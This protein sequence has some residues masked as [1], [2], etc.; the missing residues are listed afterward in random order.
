MVL[1]AP[2]PVGAV[3]P[4][5]ASGRS[6]SADLLAALR[7]R[8]QAQ[9]RFDPCLA[10][11]LRAWLE[12]AAFGVAAA[13]GE[14]TSPLFVGPRRV[15]GP[16]EGAPREALSTERVLSRLV[17]ALFR[18]LVTVG[19]VGDP[20]TDA[21]DALRADGG[22]DGVVGTVE[23]LANGPRAVLAEALGRHAAHLRDLVPRFA[24]SWMPR[25]D[26]R[27]AIPLAG[28]RVVLG[29]A[30]DLLIRPGRPHEASLCA[31]G[32]ATE[33]PW[34]AERRSLHYLVLLETLRSGTPPFRVALVE[35]ATGRW[36]LEDVREEHV[37]AVAAHVAA[38]LSEQ[39]DG[40][41]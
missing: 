20:L 1:V 30:I 27:L 32:L 19:T 39:A 21:L 25:T 34:E 38:W 9:P 4:C 11:G 8:H 37:R 16:P 15:L 13:R 18:Q 14:D 33:G 23:S 6:S 3:Q 10:G 5:T 29:G 35:S 17:R 31:I 7:R 22:A 12:D 26:D 28:G 2:D 40:H 41:G 36:G 24:P